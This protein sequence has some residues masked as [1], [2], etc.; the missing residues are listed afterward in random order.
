MLHME[1]FQ[2]RLE[3]EFGATPLLT[4]PTVPYKG[5][6]FC[7]IWLSIKWRPVLVIDSQGERII[8]NPSEF[9]DIAFNARY[10]E[11]M[12]LASLI[13][14]ETCL[15]EIIKLCEVRSLIRWRARGG[16]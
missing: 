4:S 16:C 9:P 13:C 3:Q 14:P 6:N 7:G 15:G 11:P 12:I 5:F 8:R 2:Q 1:V 10:L